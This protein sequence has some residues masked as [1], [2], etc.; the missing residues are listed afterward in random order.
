MLRLEG[1]MP[2]VA[3]V[4]G[5]VLVAIL[6]GIAVRVTGLSAGGGG[7]RSR[8]PGVVR[9]GRS[10]VPPITAPQSFARRTALMMSWCSLLSLGVAHENYLSWEAGLAKQAASTNV[11]F[12]R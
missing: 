4:V 5:G 3:P 11:R 8:V 9:D 1:T 6:L 2:T 12:S 10:Y 7:Y